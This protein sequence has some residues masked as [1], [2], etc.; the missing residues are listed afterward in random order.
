MEAKDT[1]ED[2]ETEK[3]SFVSLDLNDVSEELRWK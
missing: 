1:K 2:K 3:Y